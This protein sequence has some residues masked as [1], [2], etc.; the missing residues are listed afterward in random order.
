MPEQMTEVKKLGQVKAMSLPEYWQEVEVKHHERDRWD[1]RELQPGGHEEVRLSF[2]NRGRP[3]SL[4]SAQSFRRLLEAPAHVLSD[5][6]WWSVQEVLRDAVLPGIFERGKAETIDMNGKM[7][8]VVRGAW[9]ELN[10]ESWAVFV[11]ADGSGK[12]IQEIYYIA[13]P[14]LYTEHWGDVKAAFKSIEWI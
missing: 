9:T 3:V 6:E 14:D 7:V 8:L 2:F 10:K 1:M 5:E 4:A 11:D 12:S 13:P